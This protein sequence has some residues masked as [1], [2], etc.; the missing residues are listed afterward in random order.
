MYN[1][2]SCIILKNSNGFTQRNSIF[3]TSRAEKRTEPHC[4]YEP[5]YFGA[6]AIAFEIFHHESILRIQMSP[7]GRGMAQC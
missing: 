5:G 2:K 1:L 6:M 4:R 3:L 7:G